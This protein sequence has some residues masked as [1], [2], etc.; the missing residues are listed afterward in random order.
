MSV[1]DESPRSGEPGA[2][3]GVTVG[4]RLLAFKRLYRWLNL[5]LIQHAPWPLL[6]LLAG[7]P[8]G[9]PGRTP[10]PW[11][12]A[13]IAAP[14]IASLLALLTLRLLPPPPGTVPVARGRGLQRARSS[15]QMQAR[16]GLFALTAMLALARLA[17]GPAV[18]VA[19]QLA[20]GLADVAAFQL[21]NFGVAA[22]SFPPRERGEAVA[23]LLFGVSWAARD[24]MLA[25]LG[26]SSSV[27]LA[28]IGGLVA[29]TAFGLMSWAIRRWLGG[30]WV[31]AAAQWLLVYLVFGFVR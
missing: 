26:S 29:G 9:A 16:V 15:L 7:A 28:A 21:I 30:F 12:L 17:A 3:S 4:D 18:V 20:F 25:V 31:S 14:A 8:A 13:R 23:V 19:K 2:S 5:T 27:A 24:A 6:L 10:M 11:Y 22:R 1:S